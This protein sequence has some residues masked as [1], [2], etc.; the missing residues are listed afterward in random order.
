M[1]IRYY[2]KSLQDEE[3]PSDH[4]AAAHMPPQGPKPED[5]IEIEDKATYDLITR[6]VCHSAVAA[7]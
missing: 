3:P 6:C 7:G 2:Y 1:G 4:P 5:A